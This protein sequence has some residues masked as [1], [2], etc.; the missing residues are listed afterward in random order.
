[1]GVF[2]KKDS[3]YIDYKYKKELLKSIYEN[4]NMIIFTLNLKR[5]HFENHRSSI[6]I[7]YKM[8]NEF[9]A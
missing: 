2:N 4:I 8:M 7:F 1:M 3:K 5:I 6:H 9:I